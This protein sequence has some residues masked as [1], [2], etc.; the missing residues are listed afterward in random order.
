MNKIGII[1][2]L[3]TLCVYTSCSIKAG[4]ELLQATEHEIQLSPSISIEAKPVSK[5]SRYESLL[6]NNSGDFSVTAFHAT[7]GFAYFD[8]FDQVRYFSTQQVWAFFDPYMGTNGDY[9]R[10]YW[11]TYPLDF[12]AF[13]PHYN[14]ATDDIAKDGSETTITLSNTGVSLNKMA[15]TIQCALPL[16][17]NEQVSAKEF[18]YAYTKAQSYTEAN[19]GK[20]NLNFI[21]PFSAVRFVLG[22]AHGNTLINSIELRNLAFKGTLKA[23][24]NVSQDELSHEDWDL[25]NNNNK[26]TIT[27]PVGKTV[28]A[29]GDNGIQLNTNIGVDLIVLPQEMTD[30]ITIYVTYKWNETDYTSEVK[31]NTKQSTPWSP[32]KIYTYKLNLGDSA[33]DIISTVS[34]TAWTDNG[35]KNDIN[36]E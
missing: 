23:S 1:L 2:T 15:R 14:S 22:A 25:D 34:I 29:A 13:M 19:K 9:Y 36:V 7:E 21:H 32:G 3:C 11:P 28:G 12:L 26:G 20:V 8:N 5:V 17:Y 18:I 27:I 35:Y 33:E 10:R 31:V 30:D 4:T 16:S 24:E 6:S